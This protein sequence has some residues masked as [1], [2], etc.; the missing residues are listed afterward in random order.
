VLASADDAGA[1]AAAYLA[2]YLLPFLIIPTP[3]ARDVIA[4]VGFFVVAAAIHLRSA[5]VQVNPLLYLLGYRVLSVTD[6]QGLTAYM[7]TRHA[8]STGTPILAT[9]LRDD[10][11]IDRTEASPA[12]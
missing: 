12:P 11:L 6:E 9:R 4:Y 3:T 8:V 10:V 2:S 1:A 5:V 7:I